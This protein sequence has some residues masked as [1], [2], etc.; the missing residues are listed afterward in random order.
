M[1]ED[2]QRTVLPADQLVMRELHPVFPKR[3]TYFQGDGTT[4][5][6]RKGMASSQCS[7][8]RRGLRKLDV[9]L[10]YET[11]KFQ[12]L[13]STPTFDY[14]DHISD[15]MDIY[16]GRGVLVFNALARYGERR[17]GVD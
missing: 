2:Q 17:G 1:V 16:K 4:T 8:S 6:K 10:S 3:P 7:G 11:I 9:E 14:G 5:R 15:R 12:C 13:N